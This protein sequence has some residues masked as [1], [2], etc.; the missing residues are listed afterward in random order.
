M[1][2]VSRK[3]SLFLECVL[4]VVLMSLSLTAA[5]AQAPVLDCPTGFI[6]LGS[7]FT[8]NDTGTNGG[9]GSGTTNGLYPFS[10][11]SLDFSYEVLNAA[12]W[13]NG[14]DSEIIPAITT[15]EY[16]EVQPRNTSFPAGTT[17]PADELTIDA[18]VYTFDVQNG[19]IYNLDFNWGGLD[20]QD[21]VDFSAS[22]G[23]VN[24]P[25]TSIVLNNPAETGIVI[26]GQSVVSSQGG[27]NAPNNSVN[28]VFNGPIDQ[29]IIVAG[30]VNGNGGNVTMQFYEA[31]YCLPLEADMAI[32]KN[33]D[34]AGPFTNGQTITYTLVVTNNGPDTANNVVVTDTP[35]N[36]TIVTVSSPNCTAL[37]CT[38]ASLANGAS[39]T[40]TVT[41]TIDASGAFDNVVTVAADETDPDTSNNE[42]DDGNGGTAGTSADVAVTKTLDTAGPFTNGQTIQY[43]ITVTNNGPDTANNVVVTDTP[44]NLTITSVASANCAAVTALSCNIAS[45]ANGVSEVITVMA[46]IDSAGAFD[47]E[48]TVSADEADPDPS[49]DTDDTSNGGTA[50]PAADVQV[51]KDLDT[52]A[53]FTN[54]QTIQYTITVTNNGPDT[55]NNVVVTDTP[56]NLTITSVASA[57][58]TAFSCTIPSLANGASEMITVMATIDLSGT[59]DNEVTVSADETDPDTSNNTDDTGNAGSADTS[60]D[61]AVTKTLN[62]MAPYVAGQ[63]VQY[64]LTVSNNG[65]DTA[66]MIQVIDTPTNLSITTVSSASCSTLPCTIPSL[67][68]GAN[69][70]ITVMATIDAGGAF[71]NVVTVTAIEDDPDPSNDTDNTG[72]GGTADPAA[73]VAVVKDLGTAGPFAAGQT[74]Q[75]TIEVSNNG[76]DTATNVQVV[77]TPVNLTII[78][79]ASA[80]CT[81]FPCTIPSLANGASEVIAVSA[82]I[83]DDGVFDNVVTVSADE[84]DPDP[85]NDTDD[86]GNGGNAG[87]AA[88]VA[89]VKDLDTVGPFTNGQMVQYTITVT[90]NGPDTATN[91]QV[92][93]IPA[94]LTIATVASANCTAFPCTIPSLANG[95][96]EVIAVSATIDADG[97]FDNV[98]TVSA[99]ETDPDTSNNV[100]D[101]GNGSSTGPIA[102]VIVTKEITT[103]APYTVGQTVTFEIVVSNDGPDVAN[104][105]VITDTTTNLTITSVSSPNCTAFNCIL[106]SLAVGSSETITVSG[107]IDS[108]GQFNNAA[109]ATADEFDPLANNNDDNGADGNNGGVVPGEVQRVPTLSFW[110]LL[111]LITGMLLS[112]NNGS[113]VKRKIN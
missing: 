57:N 55:A 74:V 43:T 107:T 45:L 98:V 113:A 21:R 103:S 75:Y 27:S 100:D 41:A 58:C 18:A 92:V 17:Y 87:G 44:T 54:G 24:V 14:V 94:N 76:P 72:N 102:D 28:V 83:D 37:P 49:N 39:E 64:T 73:D 56:A 3:K 2:S 82:T 110:A 42:D 26:S 78:S 95:A 97:V 16:I 70:V 60:A 81:A 106:T 4:L 91:V 20:N 61:V 59:F 52:A 105:V 47:N 7:S 79:V 30:K 93:D 50:D 29:L 34:T 90:N 35:T 36:L 11:A 68:N 13:S 86:T 104:N 33:L 48:V 112:Y 63:T 109:A 51:V 84:D 10:G 71:D 25:V 22:L 69:E 62:T 15:G 88:D 80:N 99:D 31:T 77:D 8:N 40:I 12:T 96:S 38:I 101:S 32:T 1:I 9:Q 53:P 66:T 89:V 46:T 6:A 108:E 23:G 65:P 5:H 85:N 111:L 19:P 67:A